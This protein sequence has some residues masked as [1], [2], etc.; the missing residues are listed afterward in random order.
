M[1]VENRENLIEKHNVLRQD[2]KK[3]ERVFTSNGGRKPERDD[4][5]KHPAIGNAERVYGINSMY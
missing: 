4:I 3:W 1:E 2:L 5:K